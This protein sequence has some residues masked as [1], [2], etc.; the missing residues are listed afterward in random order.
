MLTIFALHY[1]TETFLSEIV[2][3]SHMDY[4]RDD[5]CADFIT[6]TIWIFSKFQE[7]S[8]NITSSYIKWW[9]DVFDESMHFSWEKIE[10]EI[11]GRI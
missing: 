8:G 10:F 11:L 3:L 7:M 5:T 9:S 6:P 1:F 2:K 4:I